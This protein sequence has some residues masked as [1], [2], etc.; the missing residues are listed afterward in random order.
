M[1][2]IEFLEKVKEAFYKYLDTGSR[3]N[4]KLKILHGAIANDIQQKLG[5]NYE[6]SSLGFKKDKEIEMTGRYMNKK[7]DIGIKKN[8]EA[9]AGIA[10]KYIMRNYSQN[11]NNYFENM[12][13]ETAN[14]RTAGKPYFQIIIIPSK[15]PY[16]NK[17]G[18]ITKVEKITYHQLTKYMKLSNDNIDVYMHTPNKTLIYLIDMGELPK[19]ITNFNDY[20][21]YY[22]H[23][24][25]FM[26]VEDEETY[27]FGNTVI[28]NDY[29]KFIEKITHLILSL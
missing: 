4:E 6:I 22:K 3:S 7:V 17:E 9:I 10:L 21:N 19:D 28:Y 24:K 26:V 20:I 1:N 18:E 11:T 13:G 2:N 16:F 25:T 12:L 15:V 8:E 29:E 23:K 5:E 27:E 14:I